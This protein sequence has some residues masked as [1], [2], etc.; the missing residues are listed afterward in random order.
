M[1]FR[2]RTRDEQAEPDSPRPSTPELGE[3]QLLVFEPDAWGLFL[4]LQA[5]VVRG[6]A[7]LHF[8][9]RRRI[10]DGIVEEVLDDLAQAFAV[11]SHVRQGT[12]HLGGDAHL[13]LTELRGSD[14]LAQ[15]IR[16]I[17]RLEN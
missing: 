13:V 8:P 2:D 14:E 16:E 15:Q 7:N 11:A 3:D 6:R 5:S 10:L 17:Q 1:R 9:A 4:D 12:V